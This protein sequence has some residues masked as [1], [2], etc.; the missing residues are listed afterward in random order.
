MVDW[1]VFNDAPADD[2]DAEEDEEAEDE[3]DFDAE[4][5]AV[6]STW[7]MTLVVHSVAWKVPMKVVL[8]AGSRGL[9]W[10]RRNKKVVKVEYITM[11]VKLCILLAVL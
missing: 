3:G 5:A 6:D 11:K 9:M 10:A 7:G 4:T 8:M 2:G 1:A